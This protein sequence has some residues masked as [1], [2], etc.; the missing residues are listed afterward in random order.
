MEQY[1]DHIYKS[2]QKSCSPG[3][4]DIIVEP[5]EASVTYMTF[6][7]NTIECSERSLR[8]S[9]AIGCYV[10][11]SR[12]TGLTGCS[13]LNAS[14]PHVYKS[15]SSRSSEACAVSG[16]REKICMFLYK[17]FLRRSSVRWDR[18]QPVI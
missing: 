4:T 13:I 6:C 9:M 1:G 8:N 11:D 3:L 18:M 15:G 16:L 7:C 2:Y 10:C 12:V 17:R 14:S 5:I